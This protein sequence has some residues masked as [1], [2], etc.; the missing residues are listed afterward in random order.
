MKWMDQ[1][2][3]DDNQD[4]HQDRNK[5]ETKQQKANS[6]FITGGEMGEIFRLNREDH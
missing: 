6:S 3:V 4:A 1:V 5:I 2:D